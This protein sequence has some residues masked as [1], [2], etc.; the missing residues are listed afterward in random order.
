MCAH[1]M[2]PE[3]ASED[4]LVAAL[5]RKVDKFGSVVNMPEATR[6]LYAAGMTELARRYKQQRDT[7]TD[8]QRPPRA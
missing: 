1:L 4:Q 5:K 2:N 6:Q 3:A 8:R 7:R